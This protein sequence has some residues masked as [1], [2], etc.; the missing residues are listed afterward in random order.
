MINL[1]KFALFLDYS[2][3]MFEY[4]RKD[5]FGFNYGHN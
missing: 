5:E 1:F 4:V 2:V 3:T